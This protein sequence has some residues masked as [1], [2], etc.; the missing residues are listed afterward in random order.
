VGIPI[1]LFAD[2]SVTEA[3]RVVRVDRVTLG[4]WRQ[5]DEQYI[6]HFQKPKARIDSDRL[7]GYEAETKMISDVIIKM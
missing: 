5:E 1:S 3:S 7:H 6:E 2:G 4:R